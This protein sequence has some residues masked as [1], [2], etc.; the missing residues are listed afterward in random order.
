MVRVSRVEPRFRFKSFLRNFFRLLCSVYLP[1]KVR[2]I[3]TLKTQKT[4]LGLAMIAIPK[5]VFAGFTVFWAISALKARKLPDLS[6]RQIRQLLWLRRRDLNP[7]PSGYEPDEL[8]DCSTPRYPCSLKLIYNTTR[9]RASQYPRRRFCPTKTAG[10]LPPRG[11]F[12]IK[13]YSYLHSSDAVLDAT[14]A[15]LRTSW[16]LLSSESPPVSSTTRASRNGVVSLP[17]IPCSL[18]SLTA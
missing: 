1:Q 8:P 4:G 6:G 14:M 3:F 10:A 13:S 17:W 5:P 15:L 12:N 11:F 7:R 9:C 18:L 16:M 2:G